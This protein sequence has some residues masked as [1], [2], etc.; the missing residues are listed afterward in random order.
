MHVKCR[1][2]KGCHVI[3]DGVSSMLA[4]IWNPPHEGTIA[5]LD[6]LL[7]TVNYMLKKFLTSYLDHCA[8]CVKKVGAEGHS[9]VTS[10]DLSLPFVNPPSML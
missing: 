7:T 10:P 8:S 1:E 9:I 6:G 2:L 5:H 4:K 3:L